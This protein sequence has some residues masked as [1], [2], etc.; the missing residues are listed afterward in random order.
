MSFLTSPYSVR[1]QDLKLWQGNYDNLLKTKSSEV[2]GSSDTVEG[3]SAFDSPLAT[4]VCSPRKQVDWDKK[5]I[6]PSKPFEQLLEEKLAE[7]VP[8]QVH[9][10]PK[11]PF[12]KKGSGLIRYGLTPKSA[13]VR[14][15]KRVQLSSASSEGRLGKS[16]NSSERHKHCLNRSIPAGEGTQLTLTPLKAPDACIKPKATWSKYSDEETRTVPE[17]QVTPRGLFNS[18]LL[19][20]INE[21]AFKHFVP[22]RPQTTSEVEHN[23]ETA[24]TQ[25]NHDKFRQTE[26]TSGNTTDKEL[27]IFE[28]LEERAED[29]SFSST[30]SS[31]IRLLSS[32]PHK[33]KLH[34]KRSPIREERKEELKCNTDNR[35]LIQ[36]LQEVNR[37]TVVLNDF[38]QNFRKISADDIDKVPVTTTLE[39]TNFSEEDTRS[40]SQSSFYTDFENTFRGPTR[41]DTAVNTSFKDKEETAPKVETCFS[42]GELKKQL[43]RLSKE[44]PDIQAEKARVCDFAKDLEKKRDQLSK[45]IQNLKK[46][47]E[48]DVGDL[49]E[50]LE[51]EKKKFVREKAVF[52]M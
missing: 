25:A 43:D 33:V 28:A 30:N 36:K 27:R 3:I 19:D 7:D 46:K 39:E 29:S 47:Y 52:D 16:K 1:L 48:E 14:F 34:P 31:I 21:L 8:A 42:C 49:R 18:Y 23:T 26:H 13:N 9:V 40:H 17:N 44:V 37:K 50:E 45:E 51:G 11:K 41:V 32:T 22:G 10:K 35:Q 24:F 5:A 4:P 12:L 2:T 6:T 15:N 20:R 38:L